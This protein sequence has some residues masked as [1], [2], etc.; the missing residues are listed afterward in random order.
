MNED[1]E[2]EGQEKELKEAE[3]AERDKELR[4]EGAELSLRIM[5]T[6]ERDPRMDR[7]ECKRLRDTQT[8]RSRID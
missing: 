1:K 5:E 4:R 7:V 2:L 3:G 8:M 6:R